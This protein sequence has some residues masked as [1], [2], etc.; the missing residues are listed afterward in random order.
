MRIAVLG[1]GG[2]GGYYGAVLAQRNHDV[3]FIARGAHLRAMQNRGLEVKSTS[4]DFRVEPV[5]ATDQPAEVGPVELILFCTKTYDTEAAAQQALPMIGQQTTILSLQNGVDA[6]ER[7]GNIA[8]MEHMIAGRD[9]DFVGCGGSR[10]DPT[11]FRVP[12]RGG[13]GALR[14]DYDPRAVGA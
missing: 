9:V 3:T 2:I 7:I 13:R 6:S 14:G 10:G 4:G 1:A 11:H 12:P 5:R 8:G